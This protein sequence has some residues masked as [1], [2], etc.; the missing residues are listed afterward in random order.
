M[1]GR[2][3]APCRCRLLGTV[4]LLLAL[5]LALLAVPP[6]AGQADPPSYSQRPGS[7]GNPKQQADAPPK[8]TWSNNPQ[9][10]KVAAAA[11][12]LVR[13]VDV[14]ASALLSPRPDPRHVSPSARCSWTSGL[15]GSIKSSASSRATLGTTR[16]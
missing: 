11:S 3:K 7:R 8:Q 2:R 4:A 6:V 14:A 1:A 10:S 12:G 9:G 16:V 5:A 13:P 15:R